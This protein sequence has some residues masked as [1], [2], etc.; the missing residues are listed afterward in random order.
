MVTI[1]KKNLWFRSK[2]FLFQIKD[3]DILGFAYIE[4]EI[5]GISSKTPRISKKLWNAGFFK[6]TLYLALFIDSVLV[7]WQTC[8]NILFR[9]IFSY[10]RT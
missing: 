9:L 6:G 2:N 8:E 10:N 3:F 1:E 5:L 7:T 4:F